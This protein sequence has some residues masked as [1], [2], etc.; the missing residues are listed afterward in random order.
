MDADKG[1]KVTAGIDLGA[2]LGWSVVHGKSLYMWGVY[3][4][5]DKH[6]AQRC[7]VMHT[8]IKHE[9]LER[10]STLIR[11]GI[12][13]PPYAGKSKNLRTYG[14]LHQYMG[15]AEAAFQNDNVCVKQINVMTLK[16]WA[17]GYGHAT[18]EEVQQAMARLSGHDELLVLS[19][20]IADA[21]ACAY[22]VNAEVDPEYWST[23]KEWRVL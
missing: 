23:V 12:E 11:V 15:V 2:N 20:D 21:V 16:K 8:F 9:L 19:N 4:L 14:I 3:R 18:K 13:S 10:N 1:R 22:F 5:K 17:T 7:A 6:M